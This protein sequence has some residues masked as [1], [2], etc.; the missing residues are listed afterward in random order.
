MM[1]GK[2]LTTARQTMQGTLRA[3]RS[4][5]GSGLGVSTWHEKRLTMA[6]LSALG[7]D[8][9]TG[10]VKPVRNRMLARD[11]HLSSTNH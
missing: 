11:G 4:T 5:R 1:R 8:K 2:V 7:I 10:I 3:M 9:H 6:T